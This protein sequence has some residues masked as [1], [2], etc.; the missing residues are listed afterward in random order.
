M[1]VLP[2]RRVIPDLTVPGA[3][4]EQVATDVEY[5]WILSDGT[6]V[7]ERDG[8]PWYSGDCIQI[9]RLRHTVTS[10]IQTVNDGKPGEYI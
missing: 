5:G 8:T 9:R 10:R 4:I 6:I 2:E 1:A 3:S 7:W